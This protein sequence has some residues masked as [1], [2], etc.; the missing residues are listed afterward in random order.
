MAADDTCKHSTNSLLDYWP[1]RQ[2][3]IVKHILKHTGVV[4][5]NSFVKFSVQLVG[6]AMPLQ[7]TLAFSKTVIY[8]TVSHTHMSITQ[9]N[10]IYIYIYYIYEYGL[11]YHRTRVR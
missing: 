6:F 7:P 1:K 8:G 9:Y 4:M 11:P 5:H 10:N 2:V 3:L